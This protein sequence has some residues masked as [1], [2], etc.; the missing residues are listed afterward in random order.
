MPWTPAHAPD[1][2][3]IKACSVPHLI[4][5]YLG[6]GDSEQNTLKGL[7]REIPGVGPHFITAL[8]FTR[9][10][11]A[12]VLTVPVFVVK[13]DVA[14]KKRQ[15]IHE[16]DLH[17]TAYGMHAGLS[18]SVNIPTCNDV[19]LESLQ[20][21]IPKME[22]FISL[23]SSRLQNTCIMSPTRTVEQTHGR[24]LPRV[25]ERV[26]LKKCEVK[27]QSEIFEEFDVTMSAH[28]LVRE[29]DSEGKIHIS[30]GSRH[31]ELKKNGKTNENCRFIA[32]GKPAPLPAGQGHVQVVWSSSPEFGT[33]PEK[34]CMAGGRHF[35]S[36][37]N[38]IPGSES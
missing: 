22:Q 14:F 29:R 20:W 35:W 11:S 9:A 17:P 1:Q 31:H 23:Y 10:V 13:G 18:S 26:H 32:Q 7:V 37:W 27:E 2:L 33:P 25:A 3:L 6:D 21:N 36:L 30:W 8:T 5:G 28:L 24:R 16:F 19:T 34:P 12:N 4:E 38:E 15:S